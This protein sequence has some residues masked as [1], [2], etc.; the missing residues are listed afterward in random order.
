MGTLELDMA[1]TFTGRRATPAVIGSAMAIVLLACLLPLARAAAVLGGDRSTSNAAQVRIFGDGAFIASGTLVDRNWVLTARHAV[2]NGQ[3]YTV[4]FG[5]I[6]NREDDDSNLRTIDRIVPHPDTDLALIH[7]AEPVSPYTW[8]PRLATAPPQESNDVRQYGWGPNGE[9]LQRLL[10][11]V[12]DPVAAE[13][14]AA[15]RRSDAIFNVLFPA[16][17]EPMVLDLFTQEGDSGAGAFGTDGS[18]VGVHSAMARYRH[19][20]GTGRLRGTGFPAAYDQPVWPEADWIRRIING[21]GS[22]SSPPAEQPPRRQLA[23]LPAG[24]LPM[25]QPPQSQVCDPGDQTCRHPAP[26]WLSGTLAG[27]GTYRGTALARCAAADDNSCSFNGTS[28]SAG[29]QARLPLGPTS[30]PEALG[31]REVIAWCTTRTPFPGADS[32]DQQVLRVS[33]TNA[34]DDDTPVG[35]GWW[36]LTPDQVTDPTTDRPADPSGLNAC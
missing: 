17:V 30:A 7:F 4:R 36:D 29:A 23:E 21:E 26:N 27:G 34:D 25:T 1:T 15:L 16:G 6:T 20:N 12:I 3:R 9:V 5:G 2:V 35:Y 33:F 28:Y 32:P 19:V 11:P 8:I 18:L 31:R 10:V 13:N 22:S 14:A 24:N